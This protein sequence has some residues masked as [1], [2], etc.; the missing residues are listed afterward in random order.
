M[1]IRGKAYFFRLKCYSPTHLSLVQGEDFIARCLKVIFRAADFKCVLNL[2]LF[3]LLKQTQNLIAERVTLE[4]NLA[5][6]I[7]ITP[8]ISHYQK[9]KIVSCPQMASVRIWRWAQLKQIN[10]FF[11]SWLQNNLRYFWKY[12]HLVEKH[13][14]PEICPWWKYFWKLNDAG[15]GV[16][17]VPMANCSCSWSAFMQGPAGDGGHASPSRQ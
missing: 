2:L 15:G 5:K 3:K 7:H 11:F 9:T 8:S 12:L 17:F 16:G 10:M 1:H 6:D 14:C 13:I 4:M